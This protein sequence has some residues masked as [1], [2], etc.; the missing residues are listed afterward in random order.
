MIILYRSLVISCGDRFLAAGGAGGW[1]GG[2]RPPSSETP[3]HPDPCRWT[4]SPW[5]WAVPAY[6]LIQAE[7]VHTARPIAVS[8]HM[9]STLK[10][11]L[12]SAIC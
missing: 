8:G 10:A 2:G 4:L 5:G 1:R 12:I 11:Q 9:F 7:A 6:F 3:M